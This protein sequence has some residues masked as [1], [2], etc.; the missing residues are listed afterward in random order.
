MHNAHL[1]GRDRQ[2]RYRRTCRRLH[3][4]DHEPGLGPVATEGRGCLRRGARASRGGRPSARPQEASVRPTLRATQGGVRPPSPTCSPAGRSSRGKPSLTWLSRSVCE[5]RPPTRP[6]NSCWTSRANASEFSGW[7]PRQRNMRNLDV[8]LLEAERVLRHSYTRGEGSLLLPGNSCSPSPAS[9]RRGQADLHSAR[10][11]IASDSPQRRP[12]H[13][14]E[15]A[16][17]VGCPAAVHASALE[18]ITLGED[19]RHVASDRGQIPPVEVPLLPQCAPASA[20]TEA[21]PGNSG[22]PQG[23]GRAGQLCPRAALKATGG[24]GR[25]GRQRPKRPTTALCCWKVSAAWGV[26]DG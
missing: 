25:V 6:R 14:G 20:E 1:H 26:A 23:S 3:R 24:S 15:S 2:E 18:E 22:S 4:L 17:A 9:A 11:G 19:S 7:Q 8:L 16:A 10:T 12:H 21:I 5:C 13:G